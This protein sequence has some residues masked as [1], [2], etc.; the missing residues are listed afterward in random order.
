MLSVVIR[1]DSG[2]GVG[3]GHLTRC[4]ALGQAF[5]ERGLS[6]V[7]ELRHDP[8]AHSL[9]ESAGFVHRLAEPLAVAP[10]CDVLVVDSYAP[11]RA[12]FDSALLEVGLLVCLDDERRID[13]PC[14]LVVNSTVY[15]PDLGYPR[16]A[17]VEYL[18]GPDYHPLRRAFWDA[19]PHR[20]RAQGPARVL[21]M[22]G[23]TLSSETLAL[24]DQVARLQPEWHVTSVSVEEPQGLADH[25][26]RV[27]WGLDDDA[28][29]AV[30]TSTALCV[31]AGG[32]AL[33]ELARCGVPAAAFSIT[34][35]QDMN[36]AAWIRTGTT[37][38]IPVSGSLPT[39][40]TVVEVV[41]KLG[42]GALSRMSHVGP[43]VVDGQGARRVVDE[44]LARCP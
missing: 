10:E 20:P 44:V 35:N 21:V 32:Q 24:A 18:L 22:L 29:I 12:F 25:V 31:T 38:A 4:V 2:S 43:G 40:E 5:R 33:F 28:M 1:A 7:Y 37:A 13:F 8:A 6:P 39:A 26:S 42:G 16:V 14:Q 30:Y 34:D 27:A 3:M 17:G 15:A 11:D 41:S 19:I 36:L 9:V 23:G